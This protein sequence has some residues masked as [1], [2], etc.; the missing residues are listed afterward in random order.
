MKGYSFV[1]GLQNRLKQQ[2]QSRKTI[3]EPKIRKD[4]GFTCHHYNLEVILNILVPNI[5]CKTTCRQIASVLKL[6]PLFE[7]CRIEWKMAAATQILAKYLHNSRAVR[8]ID[9]A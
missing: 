4:R 9:K 6:T 7:P 3:P 2:K 5:A 1:P 8:L